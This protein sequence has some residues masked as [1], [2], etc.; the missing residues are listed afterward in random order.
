MSQVNESDNNRFFSYEEDLEDMFKR[1]IIK[2]IDAF[3]FYAY[4][5]SLTCEYSSRMLSMDN[6][7]QNSQ[8][9]LKELSLLYN[10]GRQDI[11][12][13]ELIE[14]ISGAESIT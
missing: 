3:F 11:V 4:C 13:K 5:S 14:I 10:K 12:T 8:K 7:T 9:M 2:Y 1:I 6:A